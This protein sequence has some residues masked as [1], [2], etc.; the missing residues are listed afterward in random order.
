MRGLEIV[1]L[2]LGRA[3][4]KTSQPEPS[5]SNLTMSLVNVSL[6]L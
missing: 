2:D 1:L 3:N 6:K 4:S 5:C